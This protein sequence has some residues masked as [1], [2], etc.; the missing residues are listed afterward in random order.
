MI[1]GAH[2]IIY[3][4]DAEKDRAFF[5]DVLSLGHVDVGGGW[6]IFALPPSELALHPA[7]AGGMH[8]LYLMCDDVN[9]FIAQMQARGI[10]CSAVE[11]LGWGMRTQIRLPGGGPLGVYQPRHARPQAQSAATARSKRATAKPKAARA[12]RSSRR[13]KSRPTKKKG[14]AARSRRS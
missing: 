4:A 10:E 2:V 12:V 8:E 11:S 9:A 5:R 6:L 14:K 7:A 3:S 13:A 1:S